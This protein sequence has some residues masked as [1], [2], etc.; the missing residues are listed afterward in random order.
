M[1]AFY[2]MEDIQFHFP[3]NTY[4][5]RKRDRVTLYKDNPGFITTVCKV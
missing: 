2:V 3:W 5:E 1:F 4:T